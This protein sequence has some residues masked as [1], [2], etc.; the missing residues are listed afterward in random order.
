MIKRII[1][2]VTAAGILGIGA[3]G[4]AQ[5][6]TTT[7]P[8]PAGQKPAA[9]AHLDELIQ[10]VDERKANVQQA[11]EK[12]KALEAKLREAGKTDRADK[13]AARITK[14]EDRLAKLDGREAKA[15]ERCSQ[16]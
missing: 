16:Q 14:A 5:A 2:S 1:V 15:K 3:A 11:I 13:V 8:T 12:A 9:C 7:P 10:R 4:V 6:Q